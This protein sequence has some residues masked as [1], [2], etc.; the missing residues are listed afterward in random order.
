MVLELW[1][2]ASKNMI[3]SW[4]TAEEAGQDILAGLGDRDASALVGH[5]L[6]SVDDD[7]ETRV[8]AEGADI[9]DALQK[10]QLVDDMR[11]ALRQSAS[12]RDVLVQ[13][14]LAIY[15][16]VTG[17]DS[18]TSAFREQLEGFVASRIADGRPSP[19]DRRIEVKK[20]G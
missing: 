18:Q 15:A 2:L 7:D 19:T 3:G 20:A 8:V 9:P 17:D 13:E 1:H 12:I 14:T 4:Q 10:L 11:R 16:R 5:A 6:V